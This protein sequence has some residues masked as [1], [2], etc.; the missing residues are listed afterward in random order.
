MQHHPLTI[1]RVAALPHNIP[2][3][4]IKRIRKRHMQNEPALKESERS[5][6]LRPVDNLIWNH[7]VARLDLLGKTTRGAER[8]DTS[9]TKFSEG[10]NVRAH[11]NFSRVML[12][13]NAVPGQESDGDR[14]AGR[15]RRVFKNS[16][17]R[18]R[19]APWCVDV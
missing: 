7:K 6:T 19:L 10:G 16:D 17:I 1:Q 18:A 12:V 13:V 4:I 11:R 3:T 15:R 14:F 2:H 5:N 8:N 9:D